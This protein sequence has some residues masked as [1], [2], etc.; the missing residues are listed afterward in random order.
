MTL[1]R[2][3]AAVAVLALC[4]FA[5]GMGRLAE[6]TAD[7]ESGASYRA[8]ALESALR[9][10]RAGSADVAV[11]PLEVWLDEELAALASAGSHPLV[12]RLCVPARFRRQADAALRRAVDYRRTAGAAY[13]E[14][15][16]LDPQRFT[17]APP[18]FVQE[19]ERMNRQRAQVNALVQ[20]VYRHYGGREGA[21]ATPAPGGP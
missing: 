14:T 13:R 1:S 6:R 21:E 16:I 11:T 7:T 19:L 20:G 9:Q 18:S 15:P 17:D 8:I 4:A 12:A 10:I 2:V 3:S 5:F